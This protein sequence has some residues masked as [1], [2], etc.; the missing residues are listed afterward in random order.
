MIDLTTRQ[1]LYEELVA[2]PLE[3]ARRIAEFLGGGLDVQA[4]VSAVDPALY[5]NRASAAKA[6]AGG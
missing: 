4:M 2:H 5:R 1:L 6:S 3:H